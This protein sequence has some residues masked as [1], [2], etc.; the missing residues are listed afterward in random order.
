MSRFIAYIQL[1]ILLFVM[2]WY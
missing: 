1:Y 2:H